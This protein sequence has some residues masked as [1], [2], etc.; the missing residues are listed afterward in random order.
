MAADPHAWLQ[1]EIAETRGPSRAICVGDDDRAVGRVA[2]RLPQFASDAVRCAAVRASDLPAGELSYWLLPEARG[3]GL[4][5]AAVRLMISSLP[6]DTG[7]RSVVLDIE[8][9][10]IASMRLAERL[11][12]ERRTPTR[13]EIDR[14]GVP[15]TLRGRSA[16]WPPAACCQ[17][18]PFLCLTMGTVC[19]FASP[20]RC[21]TLLFGDLL[22]STGESF[23][24]FFR[25]P[26]AGV[27]CVGCLLQ[28]RCQPLSGLPRVPR[29]AL[30]VALTVGS[31]A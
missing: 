30:G 23:G 17:I 24:V 11:G 31:L 2:L 13:T 1:R 3:K 25:E 14:T 10:N 18:E 6:A 26:C 9:G 12:A 7:V 29:R 27:K 22:A 20:H 5:Y 16:R 8:D 15:R 4:A 19:S 28:G 21:L